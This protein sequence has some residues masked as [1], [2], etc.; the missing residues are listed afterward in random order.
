MAA[1]GFKH[2]SPEVPLPPAGL[3]FHL[4][5]RVPALPSHTRLQRLP[6]QVGDQDHPRNR[7]VADVSGVAGCC[8]CCLELLFWWKMPPCD[9]LAAECTARVCVCVTECSLSSALSLCPLSHYWTHYESISQCK[10]VSLQESGQFFFPT[11][12]TGGH[13]RSTQMLLTTN[14]QGL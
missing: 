8:S 7:H 3:L 9:W 13:N 2:C 5:T 1:H 12:T 4:M 14:S 11:G 6:Q 10:V